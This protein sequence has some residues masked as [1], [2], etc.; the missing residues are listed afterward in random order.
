MTTV[1]Q[2]KRR[3]VYEANRAAAK[4]FNSVLNSSEGAVGL[5][6]YKNRGLTDHTIKKFGL[7]F[8][9]DKWD[10]LLKHLRSLGFSTADMLAAG[11]IR[12]SRESANYYDIVQKPRYDAYD[13]CSR[14]CYCFSAAACWTTASLNI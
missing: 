13:R 11:L 5:Q 6:Y 10:G 8:A 3:R 4:Y 12:Q 7:G 1:Y 9:P 14:Q 2:K